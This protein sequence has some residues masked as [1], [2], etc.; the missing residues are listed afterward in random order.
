[1]VVLVEVV[2]VFEDCGFEF[3]IYVLVCIKGVMIDYLWCGLGQLCGVFLVC[4]VIEVVCCVVELM[5]VGFVIVFDIVVYMGVLL[6]IYF[7]MESDI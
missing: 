7:C 2:C 1:M 6:D 5:Q 4:C 3:L